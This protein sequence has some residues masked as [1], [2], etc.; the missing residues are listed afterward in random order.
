MCA[1][2]KKDWVKRALRHLRYGS[3]K[4]KQYTQMIGKEGCRG[5]AEGGLQ[6]RDIG[7]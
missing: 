3:L 4:D 7:F 5:W 1:D 2:P 6:S